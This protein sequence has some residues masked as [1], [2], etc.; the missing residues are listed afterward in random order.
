MVSKNISGFNPRLSRQWSPFLHFQMA[1]GSDH[2]IIFLASI[3]SYKKA[4]RN[5][6]IFN[7]SRTVTLTDFTAAVET[8]S[9]FSALRDTNSALT[10]KH[11]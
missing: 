8:S 11:Y 7:N 10:T 5:P 3:E 1:L 6:F 9:I 2:C 4:K